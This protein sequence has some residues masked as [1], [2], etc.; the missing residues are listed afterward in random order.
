MERTIAGKRQKF[1]TWSDGAQE[2]RALDP[3]RVGLTL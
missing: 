2:L 1:L 3:Y